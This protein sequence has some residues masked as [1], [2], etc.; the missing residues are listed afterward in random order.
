MAFTKKYGCNYCG[1]GFYTLE[2]LCQHTCGHITE[3]GEPRQICSTC[4]TRKEPGREYEWDTH[5][6][7]N[8]GRP[9]E[10]MEVHLGM[11]LLQQIFM[12]QGLNREVIQE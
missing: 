7:A 5:G 9:Y 10:I 4:R 3:P 2:K 1:E 11:P 8:S 12:G 6:C